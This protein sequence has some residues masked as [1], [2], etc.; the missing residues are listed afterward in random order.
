MK[1]ESEEMGKRNL[2]MTWQRVSIRSKEDSFQ[3]VK[4]QCSYGWGEATNKLA[5]ITNKIVQV[6]LDGKLGITQNMGEA[7]NRNTLKFREK[8][9][10][11]EGEEEMYRKFGKKGQRGKN[12]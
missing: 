5:G 7:D 9:G 12:G 2:M 10:Q 1:T 8:F 6:S 11:G 4:G 3:E